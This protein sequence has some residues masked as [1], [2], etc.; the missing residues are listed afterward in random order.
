[1]AMSKLEQIME[2]FGKAGKSKT[3]VA[4]I[5]DGTTEKEKIVVGTVDDITFRVQHAGLGNPSIII[6]GEVVNINKGMLKEEAKE[7]IASL[8]NEASKKI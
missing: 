5:Q 7:M 4:I 8:V 1:M 2:I 6:I 3:P